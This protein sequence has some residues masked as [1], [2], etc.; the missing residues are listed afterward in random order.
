TRAVRRRERRH[1]LARQ[2]VLAIARRVQEAE[3][4][5]E[6]GLAAAGRP[7]DGH[8]LA[9]VHVHVDV[10]QGVG[11]HLVGEEDLSYPVELDQRAATITRDVECAVRGRRGEFMSCHGRLWRWGSA[12]GEETRFRRMERY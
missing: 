10:R 9:L 8:V 5:E 2:V 6:C 4:G 11:L 12:A 7:R 3:Y 1:L